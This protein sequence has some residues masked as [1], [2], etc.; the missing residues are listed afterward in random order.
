M[1]KSEV[2]ITFAD[3]HYHRYEFVRPLDMS[4]GPIRAYQELGEELG[5]NFQ[6]IE[7]ERIPDLVRNFLS[8]K[9]FERPWLLILEGVENSLSLRD[10]PLSGGHIIITARSA[11]VWP[12]EPDQIQIDTLTPE[13]AH[14][15]L[16]KLTGEPISEEMKAL[17][18]DVDYFPMALSMIGSYLSIN[19]H[20]TN[21][22]KY[23]RTFQ[24]EQQPLKAGTA[25][26]VR[27]QGI[28][29]TVWKTTLESLRKDSPQTVHWMTMCSFFS[30]SEI[31]IG[32]LEKWEDPLHPDRIDDAIRNY[33]LMRF[34][35]Q[36]RSYTMHRLMQ[37]AIWSSE[38]EAALFEFY[39]TAIEIAGARFHEDW[40]G[41]YLFSRPMQIS[42]EFEEMSSQMKNLIGNRFFQSLTPEEQLSVYT[43]FVWDLLRSPFP[44]GDEDLILMEKIDERAKVFG[45]QFGKFFIEAAQEGVPSSFIK[46]LRKM[47]P[48]IEDELYYSILGVIALTFNALRNLQAS[49]ECVKYAYNGLRELFFED[50]SK[51]MGK[52]KV[53][54]SELS[55]S[56]KDDFF[57]I[58]VL[59]EALPSISDSDQKI[60]LLL[61]L[62]ESC[63][64]VGFYEE[65]IKYCIEAQELFHL[66]PTLPIFYLRNVQ[67]MFANTYYKSQDYETALEYLDRSL[68]TYPQTTL[69]HVEIYHWKGRVL[70]KMRSFDEA[71]EVLEKGLAICE[72]LIGDTPYIYRSEILL[73]L[74]LV[75]VK[76]KNYPE[77]VEKLERAK[78]AEEE[79]TSHPSS[80][81]VHIY[82]ELAFA[83][84]E[85]PGHELQ[86]RDYYFLFLKEHQLLNGI[87]EPIEETAIQ[88]LLD[89]RK[90][91]AEN[92][93]SS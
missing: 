67:Y 80:I 3:R 83:H 50:S 61:R 70:S 21:I 65:S 2:A 59:L 82:L 48:E 93:S 68:E 62:A 78:S 30:P 10:L 36:T 53:F 22:A 92:S 14:L 12:N 85:L 23:R 45:N 79:R 69:K 25:R 18:K 55:Y 84:L 7:Q 19:R 46:D 91:S 76:R 58:Y 34:N 11:D 39:R 88:M 87:N 89:Y 77:A 28:L 44:P 6:D 40:S 29:E 81:K 49:E 37:H 54:L 63:S 90:K 35:P 13:G 26:S 38:E 51:M 9:S 57:S 73:R 71:E 4:Q 16:E 43:I 20:R 32:W 41:L 42:P 75:E 15:L 52:T 60:T 72:E 33:S 17:A 1:G 64:N 5:L 66:N 24:L 56:M 8:R 27:Y 86:F 47:L 31:P 74:G